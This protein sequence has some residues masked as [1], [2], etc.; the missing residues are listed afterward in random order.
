MNDIRESDW[1]H[2]HALTPKILSRYCESALADAVRIATDT[3]RPDAFERYAGLYRFIHER[4]EFLSHEGIAHRRSRATDSILECR[5]RGLITDEEF[6]GFSDELR[7]YTNTWLE[8]RV[9]YS[10]I[11]VP[12]RDAPFA[13][14]E[15]FSCR[16]LPR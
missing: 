5:W 9:S 14:G 2:Y 13:D 1:K 6:A 10:G 12:G 4:D 7:S 15:E 11:P 8:L 3:A 16:R